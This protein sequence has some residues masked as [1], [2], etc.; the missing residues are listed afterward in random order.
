MKICFRNCKTPI[1]VNITSYQKVSNI[2]K[3][4]Q[5]NVCPS[6]VIFF[7]GQQTLFGFLI[8]LLQVPSG[9]T[10]EDTAEKTEGMDSDVG[11]SSSSVS[12]AT[13]PNGRNGRLL[14]PTSDD[15]EYVEYSFDSL[16]DMPYTVEDE[17]RM[18][19]QAI[20]ESL[21]D[22]ELSNTKN[23]SDAASKESNAVKDCNGVA[24]A[25]LEP[26]ASSMP[27]CA[28][29]APSKHTTV[30]TS[31]SKSAE[32]QSTDSH[33]INDTASVSASGSS[34]PQASTQITNGK[35]ASV[36]S[37]RTQ[38]VNGEDGTRATLVIQKSRTG[39]LIDGLTQKWGSFF[40]NND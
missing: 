35:P 14:T 29:D 10:T 34:E 39:G 9:A 5:S 13:P 15:G 8:I 36:E 32:R 28:T 16:S 17:D 38:N 40:K 21:E 30:C 7:I 2:C 20:L 3:R 4:M 23:A 11:P 26:D 33:A 22:F 12:T 19:M 25:A 6:S 31:E 24:G 18:L 37:Q 27:V 1:I